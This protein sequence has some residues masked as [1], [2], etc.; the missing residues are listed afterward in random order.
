MISIF[1]QLGGYRLTRGGWLP[2]L[3]AKQ[4]EEERKIVGVV[5][6]IFVLLSHIVLLLV[7]QKNYPKSDKESNIF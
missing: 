5:N 7:Q 2:G 6:D 1:Y 3:Q 4:A